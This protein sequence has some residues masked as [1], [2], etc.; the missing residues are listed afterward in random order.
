MNHY[1]CE[2]Y[3]QYIIP[4]MHNLYKKNKY[5]SYRYLEHYHAFDKLSH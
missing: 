2:M 1:I 3:I 5:L 4:N